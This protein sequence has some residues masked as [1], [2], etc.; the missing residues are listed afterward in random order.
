[1]SAQSNIARP[2]AQALFELAQQQGKLSEWAEQ[3][4]LLAAVASDTTLS[5]ASRDPSVSS[6]QLTQLII[7]VCDDVSGG[8]RAKLNDSDN[9]LVKQG[10]NLVQLLV[11]NGRVNAI[12][13]IAEAYVA[14]KAEA[15]KVITAA[16]VTATPISDNQQQQFTETLQSKLGRS[17]NLEFTVD[18][19][20]IGGAVIRAGDWVVDGSVKAQLEQLAGTLGV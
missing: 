6:A 20:L 11:R 15:E 9:N 18:E 4:Q 10:K 17:V 14:R 3:L 5:N 2:Y 7:D 1:M 8:G 12:G 19:E 16:M 13:D